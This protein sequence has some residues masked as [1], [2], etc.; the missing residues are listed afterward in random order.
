MKIL[1]YNVYGK[2]IST[3][4]LKGESLFQVSRNFRS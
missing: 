4:K 1:K 2:L 3:L